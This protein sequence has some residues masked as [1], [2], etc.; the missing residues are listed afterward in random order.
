MVYQGYVVILT[1][2]ISMIRNAQLAMMKL[3]QG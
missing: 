2:M 1:M 3:R